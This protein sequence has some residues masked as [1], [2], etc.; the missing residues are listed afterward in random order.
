MVEAADPSPI[1]LKRKAIGAL[2]PYVV[3]LEQGGD[4][5]MVDVFARIARVVNSERFVW[6]HI[7]LD[8]VLALASPHVPWGDGPHDEIVVAKW[9]LAASVIPYTEEV[10]RR[11]AEVL[12][13][14]ASVDSLRP[15]IPA[16]TWAWLKKRPFL[17]SRSSG[18][19]KGSSGAI[20]RQVRAFGDAEILTSYML[21]VW[22]EWDR[23]D[24]MERDSVGGRSGLAE[25]RVS[26]ME[27]F[28]G[29]GMGRHREEL[30]VRL[31]HVLEQLG[32]GLEY[33]G[34]HKP[35]VDEGHVQTAKEQYEG[36]RKVLLEVDGEAANTL[37][38]T[39][40]GLIFL[41]LLTHTDMCR[42]PFD[43]HV[44]SAALVSTILCFCLSISSACQFP[45]F[46]H[47]PG[48]VAFV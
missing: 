47:T 29:V 37:A 13:H 43:I 1:M 32:R 3:R 15:S 23:V 4:Q 22:S 42:I 40:S 41:G 33:L 9:A 10:G 11:V 19:S 38:R 6:H 31:D 20:V 28:S 2:F 48:P 35:G 16:G 34:Q 46:L 25:M 14:T 7:K 27:D 24:D 36:F 8:Q 21:L 30:I 45:S 18:R 5:R 12:L 39:S 26:I 44:R 17:P